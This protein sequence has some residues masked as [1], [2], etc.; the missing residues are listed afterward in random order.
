MTTCEGNKLSCNFVSVDRNG[1]RVGVEQLATPTGGVLQHA[2]LNS[3]DI[4]KIIFL[5]GRH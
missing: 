5:P 1:E 2:S 4:D 3:Q